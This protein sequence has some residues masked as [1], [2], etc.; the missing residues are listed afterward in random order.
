VGL[1]EGRRAVVTGGGSGIGAA[2]C[3]RFSDDGARVAV[4]DVDERAAEAVAAAVGGVAVPAD[5]GDAAA[6]TAAFDRAASALGGLDTVVNNAG[7]GNV[8]PLHEYPDEE[9]DRLLRVNLT[10]V[11]NGTRAALPHLRASGST[12]AIV[13]VSSLSGLR[14]TRGEAPYSAAKAGVVALTMSA[15]LEYGPALRVNCVSP[16]FIRTALTEVLTLPG[17]R[18]APFPEADHG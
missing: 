7:T 3:R 16:G 17:V 12:G 15:A 18:P 8:L 6:L 9:W 14:P 2:T 10:G 13:N 1:L 5:V 11:F 4:L